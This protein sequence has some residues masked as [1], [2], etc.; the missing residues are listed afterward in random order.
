MIDPRI[1]KAQLIIEQAT[2]E[3]LTARDIAQQV[4]LSEF[5]F[6]RLFHF[7][8]GST[9]AAYIRVHRLQLAAIRLDCLGESLEQIA[10]LAGYDSHSAFT[11]AFT[12]HFGVSPLRYRRGHR[13]NL[14]QAVGNWE[15]AVDD[16][17]PVR[18]MMQP[19]IRFIRRRY[20]GPYSRFPQHWQHFVNS[21]PEALIEQ[22]PLFIGFVYDIPTVTEPEKIRYDCGVVDQDGLLA[23]KLK[24][25]EYSSGLVAGTTK[26]GTHAVIEHRGPYSLIGETYSI[27]MHHWIM[28]QRRYTFTDD[29]GI[30]I[31]HDPTVQI[32][33]PEAL[34]IKIFA[35][36][37]SRHSI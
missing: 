3:P 25:F 30:E 2:D 20:L 21:L 5:H 23:S 34:R 33:N 29:P 10:K 24:D 15:V 26:A 13:A 27:L 4:G 37:K 28:S 6:N 19:E 16:K 36:L 18:I 14:K 7:E 8:T 22:K 31:Y 32:E 11:R 9:A 17:R 35:P 12:A 1:A